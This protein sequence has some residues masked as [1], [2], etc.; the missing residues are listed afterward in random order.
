MRYHL[1]E[2]LFALQK[3]KNAKKLFNLRHSRLR[4]VIEHIF[5]VANKW[6]PWLKIVPEFSKQTQTEIVYILN[7]LLDGSNARI[8]QARLPDSLSSK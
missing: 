2:T 8:G 6:V 3:L 5:R 7:R 4:N 1:K